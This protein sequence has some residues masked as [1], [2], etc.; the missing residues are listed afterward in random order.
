MLQAASGGANFSHTVYSM[1]VMSADILANFYQSTIFADISTTQYTG[2]LRKAG[3]TIVFRR[4]P[5]FMV[6]EG[7]GINST[8]KHDQAE[9]AARSYTVGRSM[10]FSIGIDPLMADRTPD[11]NALEQ[12]LVASAGRKMSEHIDTRVLNEM[13]LYASPQNRGAT[14]GR[15]S[16]SYNLGAPGAPLVVTSSNILEILTRVKGVLA[17]QNFD[18]NAFTYLI[19]PPVADVKLMNSELRQAY[20]SGLGQTTYLNGRIGQP[21]AGLNMFRTNRC[22]VVWDSVAGKWCYIL[23]FGQ[24]EAT[25]FCAMNE[26]VRRID[27]DPNSWL[28]Y[29]QQ[30]SCWDFFVLYPEML[31]YL[32]VTFE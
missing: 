9:F 24:K 17:E 26:Y 2:E 4:E 7:G 30:R 5:N 29:I 21:I 6:R 25:A 11:W 27:N 3:D 22:P 12:K 8:I 23:S 15:L 32:Y 16:R 20:F 31:G 10:Y 18:E 1:P 28:Y 13:Y 14:A 19:T